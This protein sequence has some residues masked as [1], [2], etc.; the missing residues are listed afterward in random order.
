MGGVWV[1]EGGTAGK[2]TGASHGSV[3]ATDLV[4]HVERVQL[5]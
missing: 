2:F 5:R 3:Q 4:A 1:G